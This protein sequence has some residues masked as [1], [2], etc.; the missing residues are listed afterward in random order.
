MGIRLG[1]EG[2]HVQL[3]NGFYPHLLFYKCEPVSDYTD[4]LKNRILDSEFQNQSKQQQ[5]S[6]V[7][8]WFVRKTTA[9]TEE[10]KRIKLASNHFINET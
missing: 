1:Q 5:E 7:Y 2:N 9:L 3:P 4:G 6:E 8:H 10:K